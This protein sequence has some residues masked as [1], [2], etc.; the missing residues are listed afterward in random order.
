M[1]KLLLSLMTFTLSLLGVHAATADFNQVLPLPQTITPGKGKAFVLGQQTP[2]FVAAADRETLKNE[3]AF[4]AEFVEQLTG[5][6]LATVEKVERKTP[7]IVLAIDPKIQGRETYRLTVTE[8]QL[9][10]SASTSAGIFYGIQTLRKALPVIDGAET[11]SIPATVVTDSPRFGY[12]GMMLDC[13]RHFFP[14]SFVKRY[15]DICA[16]HNMNVFHWHLTDDQGWRLEI[17]KYPRLTEVGAYRSGTVL[18]RNSDVDDG[19]RYGGFYTQ[20]QAR[21]IVE[22]ARQ[23]HIQI[24][25]EVD[26]PGHTLAVLATYPE[27]GCT[28]GPYEV[29]HSWG[30]FPEVLCLGN[31][32]VYPFVEDVIDELCDIFPSEY[33]HIGGD[34][35]P[36]TSWEACPKCK[37][38]AQ[39]NGID[40]KHLQQYFTNRIEKYINGKGRKIIG[41]DEILEGEI[42][43]SA[44]IMSWRGVE[45]GSKAAALGHDVIMTPTSHFYFDYYQTKDT[46]NEPLAIGGFLPVEKVYELDPAP[47][48]F[49]AE[50]R[51][52]VLGAQANLWC[53]YITSPNYAEYMVM[54]RMAALAEVQWVPA[55]KKNYEQFLGRLEHLK[56]IY[57]RLGYH[58]AKH[59]WK[60]KKQQ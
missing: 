50:A 18:G 25:P 60:P 11:I 44:T 5:I 22:Y 58:Y 30:V 3:S 51:S 15:I 28:G 49:S 7:T 31:D 46:W 52:H 59:L 14:I 48:G 36:T 56:T 27:L 33:I 21:E 38:L 24:I 55:E 54:P 26:L 35:C 43:Q 45:P 12:R 9:T 17:K 8:R 57:D 6:H 47:A 34:E 10:I 29:S 32:K 20:E 53:E 41:W 37:A 4:L 19:Q 39:A 23:R 13:S 40:A 1:K 16:L 42:N 2:L